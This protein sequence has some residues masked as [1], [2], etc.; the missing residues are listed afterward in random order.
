MPKCEIVVGQHHLHL[1]VVLLDG[2]VLLLQSLVH[3]QRHC[4]IY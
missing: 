2:L 4:W 3:A 1:L